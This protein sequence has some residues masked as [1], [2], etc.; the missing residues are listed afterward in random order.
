MH[1]INMYNYSWGI[2]DMLRY[3]CTIVYH[4]QGRKKNAIFE[5]NFQ[6]QAAIY[7]V[8]QSVIVSLL[9]SIK[10]KR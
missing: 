3:K 10:Y 4:F 6:K 9:M 5:T 1:N 2:S 8:L 7:M